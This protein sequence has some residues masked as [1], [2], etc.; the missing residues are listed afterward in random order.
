MMSR[1]LVSILS[2]NNIPNFLFIKEMEGKWDSLVVVSTAQMFERVNQIVN[3]LGINKEFVTSITIDAEDYNKSLDDLAVKFPL[4]SEDTYMVNLTGGTKVMSLAVYNYFLSALGAE[5]FYVSQSATKYH[6]LSNRSSH[7]LNYRLSLEEYFGLYGIDIRR[8]DALIKPALQTFTEFNTVRNKGFV[9]TYTMR[10]A[11]ELPNLSPEDRRY[12]SGAW[13]EEYAYLRI[14]KDFAIDDDRC[15][16]RSV[17]IYKDG[18]NANN[19]NELDVAFLKNNQLYVVECKV[20]MTGYA[21][22]QEAKDTIE[23]YLYKIAAITRDFGIRVKPY[24]FTIHNMGRLSE[25]S[26]EYIDKRCQM[27]NVKIIGRSELSSKKLH[28]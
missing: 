23:Q 24:I 6:S 28:L 18:I 8:D 3:T 25:K 11:N 2:D 19:I 27:L 20:G 13:F 4:G 1:V 16:A 5:F 14:K 17:K 7:L 15:I 21:A 22:K 12:Y 26:R 9:L 10:F